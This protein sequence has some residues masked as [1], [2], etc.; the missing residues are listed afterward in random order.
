MATRDPL[1]TD[2]ALVMWFLNPLG[3]MHPTQYM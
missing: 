3:N 2:N 1:N